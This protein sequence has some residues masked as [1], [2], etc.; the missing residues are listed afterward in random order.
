VDSA[1]GAVQRTGGMLG[2]YN[3]LADSLV[4][5]G[6]TTSLFL[7]VLECRG[8]AGVYSGAEKSRT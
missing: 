6:L 5:K 2:D 8:S 7:A 1:Q 4:R 3:L